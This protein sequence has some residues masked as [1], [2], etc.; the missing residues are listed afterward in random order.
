M[1]AQSVFLSLDL[2]HCQTVPVTPLLG[3]VRAAVISARHEG[4][5]GKHPGWR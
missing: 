5:C 4:S 3:S 1:P 2:S